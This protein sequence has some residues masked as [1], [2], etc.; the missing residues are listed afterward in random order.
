MTTVLC[1]PQWQG[2]GAEDAPRLVAGARRTAELI[3]A[4]ARV[5][6]PVLEA[7]GEIDAGVRALDVLVENLRLTQ[8]ALTGTA[9]PT[10]PR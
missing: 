6:V 4:D 10:R 7:G 2:S 5:T 1:V 3:P 8:K 9:M